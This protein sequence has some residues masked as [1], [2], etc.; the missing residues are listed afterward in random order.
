MNDYFLWLVVGLWGLTF[1]WPPKSRFEKGATGI[2]A[3]YCLLEALL[4]FLAEHLKN[5]GPS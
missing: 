5:G 3:V 2:I 1:I 4:R